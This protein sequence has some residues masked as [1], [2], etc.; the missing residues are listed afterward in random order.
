MLTENR[1]EYLKTRSSSDKA[2][3]AEYDYR[4]LKW[5]QTMLD[6]SEKGGLGDV[7]YVLDT[8]DRDSI[9]KYL[10]DENVNDL[11][12]LVER[13]AAILEFVPISKDKNGVEYVSQVLAISTP[14]EQLTA[15]TRARSATDEDRAR[16]KMLTDHIEHLKL[17]VEAS[18]GIIPDPR[19]RVYYDDMIKE[20][21]EMGYTVLAY[22]KQEEPPK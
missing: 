17:F 20:A 16:S 14:S 21:H 19:D 1:R 2:K 6:S 11:L 15:L 5:L 22:D 18:G 7:N 12:K 9:S 8:L 4:I 3:K 13:L 10:K